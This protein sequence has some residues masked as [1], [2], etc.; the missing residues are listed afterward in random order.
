MKPKFEGTIQAWG[1]SLGVRITQPMSHLSDLGRGDRVA[2]EIIKDGLIIKRKKPR[3][4]KLLPYSEEELVA[5]LT[6]HTAHADELPTILPSEME[7]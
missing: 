1:N 7:G 6:P 5:G 3:A 4:E 2:I